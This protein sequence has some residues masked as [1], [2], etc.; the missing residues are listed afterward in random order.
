MNLKLKQKKKQSKIISS[1]RCFS[2][3]Y[4]RGEKENEQ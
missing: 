1:Q 2:L 3:M 4:L